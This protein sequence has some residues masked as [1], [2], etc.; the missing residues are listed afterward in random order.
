MRRIMYALAIVVCMTWSLPSARAQQKAPDPVSTGPGCW[1]W[2]YDP[3]QPI[4][5][6]AK[7]VPGSCPTADGRCYV[8]PSS[9]CFEITAVDTPLV[10]ERGATAPPAPVVVE[11]TPLRPPKLPPAPASV[12]PSHPTGQTATPLPERGV[13]SPGKGWDFENFI[14]NI[15]GASDDPTLLR[16]YASM[17]KW[18]GGGTPGISPFLDFENPD[19]HWKAAPVYGNAIPINRIKPPGWRPEIEKLIGG[20]YWTYSQ[21]INQHGD[22]W[23][24]SLDRRY[25]WKQHPGD[26]WSEEAIGTLTSPECVLEARYLAFQLGGSPSGSQRV[27][28]HVFGASP[29]EYFGMR[30]AGGPGDPTALGA[31]GFPTQFTTPNVP[32][33]FMPPMD[34]GGW[35]I[36]RSASPELDSDWMQTFV[37]DLRPFIGKRMRI[38]V[39]DDR[40]RQ[41][42]TLNAAGQCVAWHPEHLQADDFRFVDEPPE[43]LEWFRHSDGRCGGVPGAGDGCSPVGRVR[44]E[45][46][47]W[48]VTDVHAHPMANTGFGGHVFWGDAAD[49][50][51]QV[52]SCGAGV[53][54]IAGSGG[55]DA[56]NPSQRITSCYLHGAIIAV[57]TVVLFEACQVLNVIPWVG[58]AL[59]V[60]CSV[61]VAAAA[62]IAL[63]VPIMSGAVLHGASKFSSGAVKFGVLFSD[64]INVLPDATLDFSTGLLP[65]TDSL[66]KA[67]GSEAAGWW[68]KDEE[69]HAPDGIGKTHNAYQADMITRAYNGGLRLAVWDVINSRALALIADGSMTSDWEALKQGTDAAKRIVSTRLNSIAQIVYTPEE[70][71]NVIRRGRLAVILGSEVDELGRMRPEGLPWP[72]SA[73]AGPDSMQKQVDDLWTLGIRKVTPVH[74][75]N[76]P[77][78]GTALFVTKYDS[79]NFFI[80]GTEPE[81]PVTS[82]DLPKVSLFLDNS[83]GVLLAGLALGD[84]SL[85]ADPI[86]PASPPWNPTNWFDFDTRASRSDDN[87]IGG[88]DRISYRIGLD[89]FQGPSLKDAAGN[90]L[91]PS[92]VLGKQVIRPYLLKGLALAITGAHCD[93]QNTTR[94]KPVTSFGSPV[95][96]HYVQVAGH[97]NALGIFKTD[98]V[99]DGIGF[100]R[101]AM[102]RGMLI[103]TDHLSQNSRIDL[104]RLGA[105]YA[106]EAHWPVETPCVRA[107]DAACGSYPFVGVHSKVRGLE[108]DPQSFEELRNAYGY[109]DEASRTEAEVKLGAST[110][111]AFALFPTGSSFIPPNTVSCT[112]DS[113][114]ASYNGPGS[115]VCHLLGNGQRACDG[116][117][118]QL[119]PRNFD[120]PSE[121]S[122]DC[123]ASTKTFAVK[124]LWVM[125]TTGGMGVTPATDFNG[126]AS[127]LKP[128]YGLALPWNTACSGDERDHTD[129]LKVTGQ[130]KWRRMEIDAQRDEFSGVWYQDYSARTPTSAL[131]VQHWQDARY[132]EVV[133]RRSNEIREDRAPRAQV[134][135]IVYFNDFGPDTPK[136]RGYRYQQGNRPGAQ[137]WPMV[138]WQMLPGLA[139]WD[140]NLDGLQ[141]IGLYP[142]LFQDMRNVGVQWE[143]MGPLFHSARDYVATWRRATKIGTAHP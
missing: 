81:K 37:F 34:P 33:Q 101:A 5:A 56:I 13:C 15:F 11:G 132:K 24:G 106:N 133:A 61:V 49:T 75:A 93:L 66:T 46:P 90:W 103:D 112:K 71:E 110:G 59:A 10:P 16:E 12:R 14:E 94:P 78:A 29:R 44:S 28:L 76:N 64:L 79:N 70:A 25:S 3:T 48:G 31:R 63:S 21:D 134:N 2:H 32:Q 138:R 42:L 135:D 38:R 111:G 17:D 73:N 41:C 20:D 121:V 109:N 22:F 140:Y 98:E 82:I 127:P 117:S 91:P 9:G 36:V 74:S 58:S 83:F 40:R 122:N 67:T 100:L 6:N 55:R 96:E 69:W 136:F 50:L 137:L 8:V 26:R 131:V 128:R 97:R 47:L 43:D 54:A 123:D 51:Q 108:I 99:N 39:V 80:S 65:Q 114:C 104:Y 95:D 88:Y 85:I 62:A 130:R 92:E 53:P 45:P 119:A 1:E 87:L 143:Q 118:A 60:A 124:Y 68:K 102:K 125:K 86:Q 27:E 116:I 126:L 113:D 141:H 84:F 4:P 129:Q 142:D 57:A 115:S 72:R 35:T 120:L 19:T 7:V 107:D 18:E 23:L 30:L 52:Y 77:I 139:G 105:A 89:G